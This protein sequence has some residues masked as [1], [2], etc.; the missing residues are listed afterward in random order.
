MSYNVYALVNDAEDK[1]YYGISEDV[2]ERYKKHI[3]N[4]SD[5]NK[6]SPLY[7]YFRENG[8]ASLK[9]KILYT[10]ISEDE[11][12]THERLLVDVAKRFG[13]SLNGKSGGQ[14]PTKLSD[15]NKHKISN[16]LK[17]TLNNNEK[18]IDMSNLMKDYLND[19]PNKK[20]ELIDRLKSE[21]FKSKLSEYN[22]SEKSLNHIKELAIKSSKKVI[23]INSKEIWNSASECSKFLNCNHSS[24]E[25]TCNKKQLTCKGRNLMYYNDFLKI[26]GRCE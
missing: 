19:N 25:K 21:E 22:K 24:V 18:R 5:L 4:I 8:K 15:E 2:N 1:I 11:A 7:T 17:N 16:S 20:K 10:N 6:K 14:R 13:I 3:T 26:E 12:M 9:L 23:D